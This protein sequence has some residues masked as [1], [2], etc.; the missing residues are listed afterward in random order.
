M[1]YLFTWKAKP[2]K[3]RMTLEKFENLYMRA[4]PICRDATLDK[5]LNT[6]I[7]RPRP[8]GVEPADVWGYL[9]YVVIDCGYNMTKII[10]GHKTNKEKKDA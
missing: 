10:S 1:D 5:W 2:K 6:V 8:A 3:K 9:I 4:Y 7:D